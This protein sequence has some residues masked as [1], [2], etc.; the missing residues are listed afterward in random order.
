M[1]DW[2]DTKLRYGLVDVKK[3]WVR[4]FL[5]KLRGWINGFMG[6]MWPREGSLVGI[7]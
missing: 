1:Q 4:G 7:W 6:M 5:M 3:G 2:R